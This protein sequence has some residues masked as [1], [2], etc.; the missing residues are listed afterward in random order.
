[1]SFI[2]VYK[3]LYAYTPQSNEELSIDEND[4]LYLL[5][6]SDVDDW[7]TVK[8]RVVGPDADEPVGLVPSNYIEP[9]DYIGSATALYDYDRQTEEEVSF[10]EGDQFQ[11]YDDKDPDWILVT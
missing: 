1:M 2:G 3:A 4:I 8:K 7:W 11:V 6:K 9:A 10:K 5:E